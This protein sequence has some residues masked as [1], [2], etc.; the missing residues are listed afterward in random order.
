M[1]KFPFPGDIWIEEECKVNFREKIQ[2]FNPREIP[3]GDLRHTFTI[4]QFFFIFLQILIFIDMVSHDIDVGFFLGTDYFVCR[5]RTDSFAVNVKK[6]N[7][8][9]IVPIDLQWYAI[10]QTVA[11]SSQRLQ[12]GHS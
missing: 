2:I 10:W 4:N 5:C 12:T 8:S 6:Y 3:I 1:S 11:T 9:S 7:G